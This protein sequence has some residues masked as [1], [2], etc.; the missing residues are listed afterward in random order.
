MK[1]DGPAVK[2]L[3]TSAGSGVGE[4]IY[5]SLAIS[6]FKT[7]IVATDMGSFNSGS[8][9]CDRAYKIMG[10]GDPEYSRT[11]CDICE[12]Q[13]IDVILSGSD[14]ELE[15]LAEL[16]EA[17]VLKSF[18]MTGSP[19]AV[20]I[21]RDK[22]QTFEFFRG[23]GLPF[24]KTVSPDGI[25]ELVREFGFPILAKP[26]GGSG[27]LGVEI[28][29]NERDLDR[30]EGK[31]NFV[32]QEYL[33]SENWPVTKATMSRED[34][35]RGHALVQ[36]DEISIQILLGKNKE[37][38]G[39]FMSRNVLKFGMPTKIFP[40]RCEAYE[41]IARRM[42]GCLADVGL[43]GPVNLQCKITER[44]PVFFE[45]NP[46]F[47]GISSVRATLGFR[48]V[49]AM[50]HYFIL[51]ASPDSLGGLLTTDYNSACCRY[52]DEYAFAKSK[53]ETLENDGYVE[54]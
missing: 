13:D 25:G 47:T 15:K 17:G 33:L 38:I 45:V 20:R 11:I 41:G 24:V 46:R 32:F 9:R 18:V 44:G 40:F 10:A 7:T 49:E 22:K 14:T 1:K 4:A 2:V 12:E 23:H 50:L 8:F 28:L 31:E 48:E 27:S 42:A 35:I 19:R 43:I 29:M 53:L 54:N 16:K 5:K 26:T 6:R 3:L 37:I 52:L 51:N 30:L 34:A 21:C 39:T 36:K